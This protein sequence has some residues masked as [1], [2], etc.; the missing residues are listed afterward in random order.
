[1]VQLCLLNRLSFPPMNCLGIVKNQF[2][3]NRKV[4][5][6]PL[7]SVPLTYM[8][9]PHC[10]DNC[11]FR[12][13]LEIKKWRSYNFVLLFQECFVFFFFSGPHPCHMEV[14]GLGVELGLQLLA[15]ATATA[16]LDPSSATYTTAHGDAG[17][18]T[19]WARPGIKPTSS[20]MLIRFVN[21]WATMGIPSKMF[22]LA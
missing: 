21:C 14:P 18:L 3:V 19:H 10:L 20:W 2:T 16:T 17:P 6:W 7:N 13:S 8:L 5:F 12:V 1:M 11:S 4:Y 15:Y 9:V 22:W